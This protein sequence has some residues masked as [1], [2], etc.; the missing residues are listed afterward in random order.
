[1][2]SR[3][4]AA[5]RMGGLS[6]SAASYNL[7]GGWRNAV[8]WHSAALVNRVLVIWRLR[9]DILACWG[10]LLAQLLEMQVIEATSQA[11]GRNAE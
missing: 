3:V 10:L 8:A 9:V 6:A 2:K 4:L 5:V 11:R 1:M 7:L